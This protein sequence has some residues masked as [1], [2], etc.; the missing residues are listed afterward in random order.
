MSMKEQSKIAKAETLSNGHHL[1]ETLEE[2][3]EMTGR[4]RMR[5]I[6]ERLRAGGQVA[7]ETVRTLISFFGAQKR[8]NQVLRTVSRA[9]KSAG[10]RTEPSFLSVHLDTPLEFVLEEHEPSGHD[11]KGGDDDFHMEDGLMDASPRIANLPT[12][13]TELVFVGADDSVKKAVTLMAMSDYS[14]L[15]V[16]DKGKLVGLVSWESIGFATV[17]GKT[18]KK[19]KHCMETK[20]MVFDQE[21]RL[22]DCIQ[23]IISEEVVLVEDGQGTITGIVTTT[24][25]SEQFRDLA[26]H[27]LYLG[28]IERQLRILCNGKFKL[29]EIK[30][31]KNPN[32]TK[33]K[34][35]ALSD[36]SFGEY[37]RLIEKRGHWERLG[38]DLDKGT[39]LDRLDKVRK[40][41]NDVMHFRPDSLDPKH[42]R[43]L[44]EIGEFFNEVNEN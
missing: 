2:Q 36:L 12:A 8:G 29:E 7:P 41:R 33:R 31:A 17:K 27:F 3:V 13:K 32:D 35:E 14:Q 18:P 5:Q 37:V 42:L 23:T 10:L 21:E 24:D 9:L 16:L 26:E 30:A 11:K 38:L 19:V 40:I 4:E 43:T 44:K 39:F 20:V 28:L 25:L 6:A 34:V 22:Y 1:E 15:P